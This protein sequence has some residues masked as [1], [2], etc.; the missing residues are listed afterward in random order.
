MEDDDVGS[1]MM[2]K[3]DCSPPPLCFSCGNTLPESDYDF[4]HEEVSCYVKKGR[5]KFE[6]QKIV[7]DGKLSKI[8]FRE[9]CRAMFIGDP[10]EYRKLMKLYTN[11]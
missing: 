9:C 8:Y 5:N 1:Y 6:A 11:I 2:T 7:L 10:I 3:D 4:F